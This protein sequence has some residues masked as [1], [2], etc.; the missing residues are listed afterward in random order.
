MSTQ[1]TTD[2]FLARVAPRPDG[3]GGFRRLMRRRP[4]LREWLIFLVAL[5]AY[6]GSRALVIGNAALAVNN[7]SGII[8]WEKS[9]GLFVELSVQQVLLNHLDLTKALN[10]FYML[11]H[12][13]V[14]PLFFIWI[15]RSRHA[16]YPYVRNAFLA[17][18]GIA[19]MIYILFPVAPPRLLPDMGF[20]DTLAGVSKI[21]LHA[22]VFSRWFNADAAMPSMHF[23]YAFMIGVVAA[24][25]VRSWAL[26]VL[27]LAYPTL[28][29]I[30]ITGT[31]N[32]YISDSLVGALVIAAGF[33]LVQVWMILWPYLRPTLMRVVGRPSEPALAIPD[34]SG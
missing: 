17:A 31:A 32:H 4:W 27:A 3:P 2:P 16:L 12:W 9:S 26:R 20:V 10:E 28:V 33:V 23:G 18:N 29:F 30:T 11:G 22:G 14:T 13:V 25:L 24:F 21:N 6:E 5:L 1:F 8:N 15:Y 34:R 19:L 7:A